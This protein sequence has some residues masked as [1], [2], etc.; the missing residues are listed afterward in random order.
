LKYGDLTLS[1]VHTDITLGAGNIAF[2]IEECRIASGRSNIAFNGNAVLSKEKLQLD[3]NAASDF[4][5]WSSI[6]GFAENKIFKTGEAKKSST[7]SF[8]SGIIKA[9]VKYLKYGDLTLS[10]VHTDITLGKE[11]IT[12]ALVEAELCGISITG[13]IETSLNKVEFRIFPFARDEKFSSSLNCMVNKQQVATGVF[14]IDGEIFTKG[15]GSEITE[16]INGTLDFKA[17]NGRI[18]QLGFLSKIFALL[19]LTEIFRGKIPDIVGEGFAYNSITASGKLENGNLV[20]TGFVIDGA[21]MAIVCTGNIDLNKES[22]DL[23]VLI[24]PFK[25]FDLIIKYIPVV[26]QILDGNIISIPFR[27]TGKISD[28]DVIPLSPTAIGAGLL[29]ML[30]RTIMLPIRI[31]QP[32]NTGESKIAEDKAPTGR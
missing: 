18:Y 14:S 12:F 28:P 9:K 26:T 24:S 6:K 1:P 25:T 31:M 2:A 4:L 13:I 27:V 5:E 29:N 3:L 16:L 19:N 17:K 11:N 23:V 20:I 8:L 10:P 21:S 30:Q 7:D 15:K 32:V 22:V